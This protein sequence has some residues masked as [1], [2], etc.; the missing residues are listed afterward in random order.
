MMSF[1]DGIVFGKEN[2]KISCYCFVFSLANG[3]MS[4]VLR[5]MIINYYAHL[6]NS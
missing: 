3:R 1:C 6:Y 4:C 5:Q 2:C